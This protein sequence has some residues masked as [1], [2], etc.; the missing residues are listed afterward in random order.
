MVTF[1]T[2][3]GKQKLPHPHPQNG[4]INYLIHVQGKMHFLNFSQKTSIMQMHVMMW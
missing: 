3:G 2:K 4:T 1:V